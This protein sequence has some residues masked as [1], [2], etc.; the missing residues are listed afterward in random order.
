MPRSLSTAHWVTLAAVLITTLGGIVAALLSRKP[1]SGEGVALS[2]RIVSPSR[3]DAVGSSLR[4]R[5]ELAGVPI[6]HHVWL[7]IR[8]DD[9]LW[10]K[11]PEIPTGRPEWVGEIVHGVAGRHFGLR[12]LAVSSAG[13]DSIERWLERGRGTGVYAGLARIPGA[14]LLSEV[15]SLV[16]SDPDEPG[17]VRKR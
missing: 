1:A 13:Q 15:D 14:V 6:D 7:V 10:P 3:R 5:V 16:P 8:L 17:R 2:G 12:L 4:V 9:R 11:E